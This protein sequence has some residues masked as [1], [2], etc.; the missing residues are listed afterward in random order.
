MSAQTAIARARIA[1][2]NMMVDACTITRG[3][4][5]TTDDL[6]GG[7][8]VVGGTTIYTGKC[9]LQQGPGAAAQRADAGEVVSYLLGLQVHLPV[10]GSE[11]V[12]RG[13]TVTIT[14][15]TLDQALANRTFTVQDLLLKTYGSSR[16]LGCEEVI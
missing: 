8:T 13:D 5:V 11:A 6:T 1:A 2:E 4:T 7:T 15:A 12:Q 3:G 16:R 9:K 10:V 14:T